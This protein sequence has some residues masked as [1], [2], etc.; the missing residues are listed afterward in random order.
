MV[1]DDNS[2]AILRL[3]QACMPTVRYWME[4]EVHVYAFSI[5]ANVLL[6]FYPFLIVMV[7]LCRYVLHWRGAEDAIL[8]ALHDYFPGAV[9]EFVGRNLLVTVADRGPLQVVSIALLFFTANGV[10]EPL[11]VALN[12]AWG[13]TKN[14]SFFRNQVVSLGL[15]FVVGA[16]VLLS[17]ILTS[18]N[19]ELALRLTGGFEVAANFVRLVVFKVF[20]FLVSILILFLVYWLLPNRR[21]P[22]RRV[23]PVAVGVGFALELL[24]YINLLTLPWFYE[25][26]S[27][28]YGVFRNSVAIVLWSFLAAM[29]VLAGAE[30]S[31][32]R[33]VQAR[34]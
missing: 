31:A 14:R 10:F 23:L 27:H 22:A 24:K 30:W 15:I 12:R 9:G 33:N 29:V 4:T 11:E 8:L 34:S 18:A 19:Q 26:L 17:A 28:E 21:M 3:R 16:L 32:R 5:A 7:S 13:I 2:T 1:H 25:K 20:A 6:S